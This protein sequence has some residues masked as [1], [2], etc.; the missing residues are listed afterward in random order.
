[1]TLL[2]A[3][4]V[5]LGNIGLLYDYSFEAKSFSQNAAKSHY[6]AVTLLPQISLNYM[7]DVNR[8]SLRESCPSISDR[9]IPFKDFV[10]QDISYDLLILAVPTTEHMTVICELVEKHA[11]RFAILEKPCGNNLSDYL[12][13]VDVLRRNT[14]IWEVNY[15]RSFLPHTLLAQQ[16]FKEMEIPP[17]EAHINGY[18]DF[19]N[20]FSHFIH[21]LS[22]FVGFENL[23]FV[24]VE[25]IREGLLAKSSTGFRVLFTNIGG[26][27]TDQP[28]LTIHSKDITLSFANNGQTIRI[29][30]TDAKQ[31]Q[32][33]ST[34]EFDRYQYL[35]T[36]QYLSHFDSKITSDKSHVEI[37]HRVQ[38]SIMSLL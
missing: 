7:V 4:L 34:D 26:P 3:A 8:P 2:S 15:F 22:T 29:S 18:G 13:I 33:F 12:K 27:K 32:N 30:H 28:I 23:N 31:D 37:V 14:V 9:Y 1:M 24:S 17:I 10:S 5:G 6:G 38:R 20:I 35:A 21:L 19:L 36:R 11:F 25:R 16:A